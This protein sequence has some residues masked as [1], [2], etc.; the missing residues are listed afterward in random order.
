[1]VGS[2]D[3]HL[4]RRSA[5]GDR[6]AFVQ[7]VR[8][9][10]QPLATLIRYQIDNLHDAEDILQETLVAAWSGL[11]LLRDP[12]KF[13]AWL[14][15]VARNRCRDFLKSTQR[16]ELPTAGEE[17]EQHVNRFGRTSARRYRIFAEVVE[18]LEQVPA[19]E[20]DIA[21]L[22]YLEGL[23]IHEIAARSRCPEGT[24]KRRLFGA[25]SYMRQALGIASRER[26]TKMR[27]R[28]PG[29]KSQ[30]F[31]RRRPE[32]VIAPLDAKPFAVDCP[33]L[34]FWWIVPEVGKRALAAG[35]D[36]FD[37]RLK[38]ASEIR[39]VRP[40]EVEGVEG[41][42][43]VGD[44]WSAERGW[45]PADYA[46]YGRLTEHKA[47]WLATRLGGEKTWLRTFLDE[48]YTWAWPEMDRRIE[49]TGR[50][51]EQPDGS[52][53]QAHSP[54]DFT[55]SGA[56]VF[57]VRIGDREFACL[58]VFV[59]EGAMNDPATAV[60]ENY[61]TEAGRTVFRRQYCPH[62]PLVDVKQ[63]LDKRLT[64]DGV[65][66]FQFDGESFEGV[67]FGLADD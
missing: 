41:V 2:S 28:K 1:M 36:L 56:G 45:Q 12:D 13:S 19:V 59:L 35:Y 6:T 5:E 63:D 46:Y 61:V 65:T 48:G 24:V 15:Q 43:I 50:F 55:A 10:E 66:L 23:T 64:I 33:E 14:L 49:D 67:A 58:R 44:D 54:E 39:A 8:R 4:V 57:K 40:A 29:S 53:K 16:R 7:L 22:F 51:V 60:T 27:A 20:R 32:I 31:P 18:A 47:Q 25:R 37:G 52:F 17:L 9:H 62:P 34:R 21:K 11:R 26:V 42:E 38:G 30:P 3:E